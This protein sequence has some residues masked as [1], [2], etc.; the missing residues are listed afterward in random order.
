MG[1]IESRHDFKAPTVKMAEIRLT[2]K[3]DD[4]PIIYRVSYIPGGAGF[5]PSTVCTLTSE[6]SRVLP[7]SSCKVHTAIFGLEASAYRRKLAT[8]PGASP[9][10]G[11][12][13]MGD[14]AW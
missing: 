10:M 7:A 12:A 1:F 6:C 4:Y 8:I 9:L 2:T 5:Q 14:K 13:V 11:A 3:D